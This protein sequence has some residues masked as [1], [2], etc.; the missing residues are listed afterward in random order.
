MTYDGWAI[1]PGHP[2]ASL[3][4]RGFDARVL[5]VGWSGD[6]KDELLD[7]KRLTVVSAGNWRDGILLAG[8]QLVNGRTG[9]LSW[10]WG[11]WRGQH[12]LRDQMVS[13]LAG[14]TER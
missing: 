3:Q 7:A 6:L 11:C 12:F 13:W 5:M 1:D 8:A 4:D 14:K 9:C 2:N 10:H